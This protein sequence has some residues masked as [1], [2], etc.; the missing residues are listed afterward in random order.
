MATTRETHLSRGATSLLACPGAETNMGCVRVRV[1]TYVRLRAFVCIYM[2][3]RAC[4]R[5]C[6][7]VFVKN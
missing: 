4:V 1:C 5:A 6:V 3:V 2:C 7:C